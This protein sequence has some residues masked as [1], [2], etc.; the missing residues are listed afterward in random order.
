MNDKRFNFHLPDPLKEAIA[1]YCLSNLPAIIIVIFEIFKNENGSFTFEFIL[2]I[3]IRNY[4]SGEIL[5]YVATLISPTLYLMWR[6]RRA[7][8]H[9]SF[10]VYV[11]LAQCI[12][13]GFCT[14]LFTM[15][16]SNTLKNYDLSITCSYWLYAVS[17]VCWI[18]TLFYAERLNRNF[19]ESSVPSPEKILKDLEGY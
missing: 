8:K 11:A 16:R 12:T 4:S 14:I 7:I 18:F 6:H 17:L 2:D 15:Y 13:L 9:N 1:I 3:L 10:F 5:V 19:S